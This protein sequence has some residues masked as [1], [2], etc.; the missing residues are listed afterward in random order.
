MCAIASSSRWRSSSLEPL[1]LGG[2]VV[3]LHLVPPYIILMSSHRHHTLGE[4]DVG[5]YRLSGA[6]RSVPSDLGGASS[7]EALGG[8][9]LGA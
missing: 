7:S 5:G 1:H 3:P 2:E 6:R 9:A 8:Y 4:G